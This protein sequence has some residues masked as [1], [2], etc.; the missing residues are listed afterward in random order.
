M[1]CT[2]CD[3]NI[4]DDFRF[5]G[6]CGEAAPSVKSPRASLA[7]ESSVGIRASIQPTG[8]DRLEPPGRR[9]RTRTQAKERSTESPATILRATATRDTTIWSAGAGSAMGELAQG[10]SVQL[11]NQDPDA[12]MTYIV[13]E[14][15]TSGWV[16]NGDLKHN[17]RVSVA[18][19]IQASLARRSDTTADASRNEHRAAIGGILSELRRTRLYESVDALTSQGY[20]LSMVDDD[21]LVAILVMPEDEFD[22]TRHFMMSVIF[23]F[24]AFVWMYKAIKREKG[25]ALKVTITDQGQVVYER[26]SVMVSP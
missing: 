9:P 18:P 15:G 19:H 13:A 1:L 12:R 16:K 5:C 25:H 26:L 3:A 21:E 14:D 6:A 23:L 2:R 10:A 4:P 7:H 22:H 24:W 20:L 17:H 8:A 11:V